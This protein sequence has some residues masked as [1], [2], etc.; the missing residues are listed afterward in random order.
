MR[1]RSTDLSP[2]LLRYLASSYPHNHDFRLRGGCLRPRWKLWRRWRRIRSLYPER[3]ESLLDLSC[4]KGFFVLE[5]AQRPGC[6]RALGVD[7]YER[8]LEA[9]GALRAALGVERAEFRKARL[10]EV[11]DDIDALGGP[12]QTVLLINTYPYLYFGSDREPAAYASH[13]RIF[14]HLREVT[15]GRLIFSN[16]LQL[17]RCP[18]HVQRRAAELGLADGFDEESILAAARRHF[19]VERRG[20][21]GRIPLLLLTP[22]GRG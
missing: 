21:L 6:R 14:G 1:A 8:D 9:C 15:A 12:F 16:R 4:C 11:A 3:V 17:E 2:E 22:R 10:H 19:E 18:R 5:A 7:V 20:R 13:E